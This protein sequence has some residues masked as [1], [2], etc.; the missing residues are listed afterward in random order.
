MNKEYLDR[1]TKKPNSLNNFARKFFGEM[2]RLEDAICNRQGVSSKSLQVNVEMPDGKLYR[3]DGVEY[4]D[5]DMS[6]HIKA[7]EEI[8][9]PDFDPNDEFTKEQWKTL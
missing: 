7:G 9:R 8:G 1:F 3:I 4:D 5:S 6:I 2:K